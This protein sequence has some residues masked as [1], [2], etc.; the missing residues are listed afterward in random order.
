MSEEVTLNPDDAV[1]RVF[2]DC[3]KTY[4][5]RSKK[6]T[7][8][9]WDDNF[10]HI[11]K[12]MQESGFPDFTPADAATV[13][14]FVKEARQDAA[15]KSGRRDFDDDSFRDSDIDDINYRT[16]RRALRDA[17]EAFDAVMGDLDEVSP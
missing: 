7:H 3:V 11:A 16:I 4:R 10:Q 2:I 6:Y 5:E 9:R 13:L 17:Q 15:T 12:R 1:E 8:T 14:M